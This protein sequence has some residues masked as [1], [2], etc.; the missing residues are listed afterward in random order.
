MALGLKSFL[1]F[2]VKLVD[3]VME[4]GLQLLARV[5]AFSG[6]MQKQHFEVTPD[7]ILVI[8][9]ILAICFVI[10]VVRVPHI[11]C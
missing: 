4:K 5:I 9:I 1:H 6:K 8:V 7:E 11:P 3:H 10:H 2:L